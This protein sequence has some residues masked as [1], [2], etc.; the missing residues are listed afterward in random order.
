MI[1]LL[2]IETRRLLARRVVRF[3]GVLALL[4]M[5]IAGIVLFFRSHRAAGAPI[6][7]PAFHLTQYRLV[8][9]GLSGLFIFLLVMLGATSAGAEWHAGTVATQLTWEPRRIRLLVAKTIVAAAFGFLALLLAEAVLLGALAPAAI[10]RGTTR[11]VDAAWF[12]GTA[13][14]LLRAAVVAAL[15]AA[16]GHSLAW[17]AR[18]TAV[19]VGVV[20]GYVA[21]VEPLLQAVRPTWQLWFPVGNAV[22][23][24][25]ANPENVIGPTRS[26]GGAGALLV[27]YGIA[28][29]LVS[30]VVFRRRDVT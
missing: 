11:G 20:L 8:A 14:I 23:F 12:R 6:P 9:E 22:R 17:L 26:T 10:F 13:V 15:G 16:I 4:G 21:V 5:A 19:A 25:S 7:D 2:G 24:I 1:S 27:A 3:A 30:L 28:L 29:G 18:N